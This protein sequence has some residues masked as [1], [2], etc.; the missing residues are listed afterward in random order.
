MAATRAMATATRVEGNNEGDCKK[1]VKASKGNGDGDKCGGQ[2]TA[3]TQAMVTAGRWRATK[4]AI[5][6]AASA[7]VMAMTMAG[8]KEGDCKW[9]KD[10]G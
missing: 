1:K 9:A 5:M 8:N 10:I 6:R 2:A 7:I 3:T 4:R